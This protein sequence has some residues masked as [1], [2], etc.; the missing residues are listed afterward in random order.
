MKIP[1]VL[2]FITVNCF[3]SNGVKHTHDEIIITYKIGT[4]LE[5]QKILE[6]KYSLQSIRKFRLTNSIF[7]KILS[8]E[9]PFVLKN[10]IKKYDF[11]KIV[12]LNKTLTPDYLN[13]DPGF[14]NQWYME[15]ALV[16]KSN[17]I[18]V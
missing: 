5:D 1:V 3:A 18:Q 14:S 12:T 10:E 8:T 2:F 11:V 7:Y 6:E 4:S 13:F 16:K 17:S 15:N 9:E